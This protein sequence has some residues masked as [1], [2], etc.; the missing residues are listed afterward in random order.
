MEQQTD[1]QIIAEIRQGNQEAYR[2][3]V[4]RHK[5]YIY[6]L[7][8]REL[9]HRETAEDLAQEVFVKLF[10]YLPHF[11]GEAKFTT[12]MYRLAMNTL[13]DYRRAQKRRP[14]ETIV[15]SIKSWFSDRVEEE[16][17]ER[18]LMLEEQQ[19]V[20]LV[21]GKLK[22][23]YRIV[24]ELYHMQQ[25]S[26]QEISMVLEVPLRTV[27]TRLY[28]AKQQFERIWMEV[29]ASDTKVSETTTRKPKGMEN[30]SASR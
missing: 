24:L 3:L 8:Y 16:P 6:N 30:I 7:M 9:G 15:D 14:L 21:L 20:Q 29:Q 13:T 28:R 19:E 23:K 17:E 25:L 11:R 26:Y 27:E 10:R 2:I 1:D 4:D 22:E 12:W 5:N 18:L